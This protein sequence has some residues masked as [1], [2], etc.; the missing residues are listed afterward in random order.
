[1]NGKTLLD[2]MSEINLT[3]VEEAVF[4]PKKILRVHNPV[5]V[6][7]C[8]LIIIGT[9]VGTN[10]RDKVSISKDNVVPEVIEDL[11][12]LKYSEINLSSAEEFDYS[13]V[14]NGAELCLVP[15]DESM[16]SQCKEHG[17]IIEG[18][19]SNIYTKEYKF[20]ITILYW[21]IL[22]SN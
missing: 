17:K 1:M 7:A 21:T 18:T 4:P 10:N 3:Y 19:V 5:V 2:N 20:D 13:S 11:S 15:F 6:A 22:V 8:L 14:S 9:Y 16:L 12:P